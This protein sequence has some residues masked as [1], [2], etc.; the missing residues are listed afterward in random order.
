[1]KK[2]FIL[3]ALCMG[4]C[5]SNTSF[6]QG[7]LEKGKAQLNVGVGLSSWGAPLYAGL[8]FGVAKDVTLGAEFSTRRYRENWRNYYYDHNITGISGNLNYHFNRVLALPARC[9]FYGGINVGYVVWSSP[10]G[11]NGDGRSNV[12]IGAQIGGRYFISNHFGFNLEFGGGN[13]FNGGKLGI[14]FKF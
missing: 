3:F 4:I 13:A 1:M 10:S 11:Y 12:G 8:D 5:F 6:G 14:T 7:S 2:S 9:D